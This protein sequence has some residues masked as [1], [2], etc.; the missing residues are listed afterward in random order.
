LPASQKT[1]TLT[2][3]IKE[4]KLS[5]E[6]QNIL[7]KLCLNEEQMIAISLQNKKIKNHELELRRTFFQLPP[8]NKLKLLNI[9]L[10]SL[11]LKSTESKQ[12]LAQIRQQILTEQQ[13]FDLSYEEKEN[14]LKFFITQLALNNEQQNELEN[15]G[16]ALFNAAN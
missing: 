1:N 8:E 15:M 10:H 6:E 4:T 5:P 12:N 16:I 2:S 9:G 14:T 11:G 7:S 3:I 13:N